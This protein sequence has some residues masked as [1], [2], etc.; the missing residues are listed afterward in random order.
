MGVQHREENC[1]LLCEPTKTP[2]P[3][4]KRP[5]C[6]E[7]MK[8]VQTSV[9]LIGE[10]SQGSSYL[11]KR[12]EGYR[13]ECGFATSYQEACSLLKLQSFDLVL[14]P[15]RLRDS[16]LFPL[17]NQLEGSRTTLFFFQAAEESCW[18]LPALRSGRN[19]FGSCALRPNEFIT[20]LG[21]IM[22]E[23]Q[24]DSPSLA[25]HKPRAA[26][27]PRTSMAAL[28]GSNTISVVPMPVRARSVELLKRRA[29]R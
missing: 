8:P 12:L 5:K 4:D 1:G 20:S 16:S 2:T 15:T 26:S 28:S 13:C 27:A 29:V 23:I 14:S 6:R 22:G 25:E 7:K 9:L 19:C 21:Q 17:V 18:W 3:V 11:V 10:N 24:A